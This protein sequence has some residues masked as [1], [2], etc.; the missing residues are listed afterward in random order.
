M[1]GEKSDRC[2]GE[3]EGDEVIDGEMR[4]SSLAL[5]RADGAAASKHHYLSRN[6]TPIRMVHLFDIPYKYASPVPYLPRSGSVLSRE[7]RAKL[8]SDPTNR[9][10]LPAISYKLAI[11]G[12]SR[13]ACRYRLGT[14]QAEKRDGGEGGREGGSRPTKPDMPNACG[15]GRKILHRSPAQI[16]FRSRNMRDWMSWACLSQNAR[17]R[18]THAAS[19]ITP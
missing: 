5:M 14:N 19:D 6:V 8:P 2:D 17:T 15:S 1:R 9:T 16:G 18:E 7:A 13:M 3:S 11:T 12:A 4:C 10:F